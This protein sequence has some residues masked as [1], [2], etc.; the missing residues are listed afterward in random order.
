MDCTPENRHRFELRHFGSEKTNHMGKSLANVHMF[1]RK[2]TGWGEYRYLAV[3]TRN[4]A[5]FIGK[6]RRRLVMGLEKYPPTTCG[7]ARP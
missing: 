2:F 4:F 6:C 7:L 3:F 1:I 5:R